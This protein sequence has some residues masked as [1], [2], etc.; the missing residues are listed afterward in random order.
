MTI[1]R[2]DAAIG[3][4]VPIVKLIVAGIDELQRKGV[5]SSAEAEARR[6]RTREIVDGSAWD[7][8]PDPQ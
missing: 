8:E 2:I 3:A 4:L 7:I 6:Q 1:G 5:L